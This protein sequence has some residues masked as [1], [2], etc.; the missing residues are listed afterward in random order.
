MNTEL[1]TLARRNGAVVRLEAR[2]K[3][4]LVNRLVVVGVVVALVLAVVIFV[5]GGALI[6]VP[7]TPKTPNERGV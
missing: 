7:T 5:T 2:R 1:Q 3:R 6:A 4:H